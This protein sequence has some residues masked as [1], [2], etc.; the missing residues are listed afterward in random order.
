MGVEVLV[1]ELPPLPEAPAPTTC[2][3][4]DQARISGELRAREQFI[5]H[6]ADISP[7]LIF[8]YDARDDQIVYV[9]RQIE[10]MFG[11]TPAELAV[12][13]N[14]SLFGLLHPDDVPTVRDLIA[15]LDTAPGEEVLEIQYRFR[16]RDG[17]WRWVSGRARALTRDADGGIRQLIG[18]ATNITAYKRTEE[19]LQRA[20]LRSEYAEAAARGFVYEWDMVS[21]TV[22]RSAGLT[23][24]LGYRPGELPPTRDSW[25]A[26]IHPEDLEP[27]RTRGRAERL[28]NDSYSTEYRVR[29]R[30]G[31][32]LHVWDRGIIVRDAEG[33]SVRCIGST[34]DI[35]ERKRAAAASAVLDA[36]SRALSDAALDEAAIPGSVAHLIVPDFADWCAVHLVG[37]D[38][39]ISYASGACASPTRAALVRELQQTYHADPAW[40]QSEIAAALRTRQP[41]LLPSVPD[42]W[43]E[44][45]AAEERHRTLL[46]ELAPRSFISIPL[47]A[48]GQ[49]LG[50][51]T[52]VSSDATRR[53]DEADRDVAQEIA[54]RLALALDNA[55]LYRQAQEAVRERDMLFTI[56]T[57]DLR[58]ALTGLL[59]Q[60]QLLDRRAEQDG[61]SERNQRSVQVIAEQ[62]KRL[63]Q[64]ITAL[65]D[66]TR[67]H[68]GRL[69]LKIAPL[70]LCALVEQIVATLQPS[71][72]G[73]RLSLARPAAPL[74]VAGDPVRLEQVVQNLLS[75]AIKYTPA[76]GAVRVQLELDSAFASLSVSDQGIGIPVDSIPH[77]FDCF[78]RAPNAAEQAGSSMGIGLYVVKEIVTLHG[79][80]ISVEST[81]GSGSR[82]TVLL[83]LAQSPDADRTA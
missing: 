44:S 43:V 76:G 33:T 34:V 58:N 10:L 5:A 71:P 77:L 37:A 40:T 62:A 45:V 49:L 50:T 4:T 78:Y 41:V 38:G 25:S 42:T 16:H 36:V 18:T 15:R 26:L 81:E 24:L 11:Y 51:L 63:N 54:R 61:L 1:R 64:M 14:G 70:D 82:F 29:H 47:V 22:E 3:I 46:R 74:M 13:T 65:M 59:G 23:Q 12:L 48:R 72:S 53:Y 27:S 32:Y 67:L 79:G 30:N 7:C 2:A 73:H 52:W 21:D 39:E 57:H 19:A 55:Q 6:I 66:L 20:L 60:A 80:T 75:N 35:T 17:G 83:P 8:V 31:H 9:N 56:A 69:A 28:M 68:E